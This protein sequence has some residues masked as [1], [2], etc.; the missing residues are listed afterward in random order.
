MK[1][2]MDDDFLLDYES[3]RILYHEYAK[4][5]PIYDYH[6]HL[7]PEEIAENKQFRNLTEIWLNGDHYKWR[8]MRANGISED[9]ITG[10]ASDKEKFDAW[11][12]T[13]PSCIGNPLYHWTHLELKR[14]FNIDLP[15]SEKTGDEIWES[16]NHLLQQKDFSAQSIIKKS[17]VHVICTTDDPADSLAYHKEIRANERIETAVLPAFRPDKGIEIT[18]QGFLRYIEKLSKAANIE[19]KGYQDL[20][21]AFEN[22]VDYFDE[23]GCRVS[24]H[25]FDHLFYEEAALE[26]V[27]AIFDKAIQGQSITLSEENKYKTYTLLHLGKLYHS[28]GWAMQLHIGAIRNNNSKMFEKIGP[29]AGFDSMNDF[30]LAK[31]LNQF[32]SRLDRENELPKTILYNLNPAHNPIIA[33]AVGNFQNEEARGKLQFG[34]GWW[35]ND[36]KDGMIRQMTD[37]A[38]IGLISNFVGMVTDSRS[39]LSYTRHEYFRRILCNLIGG[40]VHKGEAPDDYELLGQMVQDICYNNAKT[41]FEITR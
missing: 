23:A 30:E 28:H 9:L 7:S 37:L 24:D 8:A 27:S 3:S 34:T 38:S 18:Q 25:G 32:L 22:R 31:P 6:C 14:Y 4:E 12:K 19:I 29:D 5:M 10:N 16:C 11:A 20:L 21:K 17:N 2:F 26:E 13:M 40:W 41:Y 15:L 33:S 1:K 35:F 39:F 36:Q